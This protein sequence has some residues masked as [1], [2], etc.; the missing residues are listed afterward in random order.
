MG[1][2]NLKA[3][4]G[5]QLKNNKLQLKTPCGKSKKKGKK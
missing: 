3:Q 1:K 2:L 5:Q 4:N